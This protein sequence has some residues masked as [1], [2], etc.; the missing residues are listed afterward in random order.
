MRI[1]WSLAVGYRKYGLRENLLWQTFFGN[2][3]MG[4]TIKNCLSK[5]GSFVFFFI[6]YI[7]I[8]TYILHFF[9][10]LLSLIITFSRSSSYKEQ[11]SL[12]HCTLQHSVVMILALVP[13]VTNDLLC[14]VPGVDFWRVV[15]L[16]SGMI[17]FF[18]A[19]YLAK[20]VLFHYTTGITVGIFG[21]LLILVY[22][23]ARLVPKVSL[24]QF[25]SWN[26]HIQ[27]L[28]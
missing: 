4:V 28:Q 1:A 17:I 27:Y 21:S 24:L 16:V 2:C 20:N 13:C 3:S 22:I 9:K 6:F 7:H 8:F 14:S 5:K 18:A 10:A 25:L 11:F 19:R 26:I 23:L 15:T 12:I